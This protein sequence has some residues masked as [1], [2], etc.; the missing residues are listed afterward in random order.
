MRY[1]HA[2]VVLAAACLAA[3]VAA[4]ASTNQPG[5]APGPSTL[6]LGLQGLGFQTAPGSGSLFGSTPVWGQGDQKPQ[7]PDY[8][9]RGMFLDAHGDFMKRRE[10]FDPAVEIGASAWPN[11]RIRN[12]DGS[13]DWL[14]YNFDI[15]GH[16]VIAPDGYVTLGAYYK[17][18]SYN[19]SRIGQGPGPNAGGVGD[20]ALTGTGVRVGFGVFLD[21]N[22]LFEMESEP[23]IWSDMDGTLHSQDYDYPSKALFTYRALPELYLKIGARYN[24]IYKDAPWLPYLGVSWEFTPGVRIDLLAPES[25]ELS[26]WPNPSLGVLFGTEV[27]GAE[28]HVRPSLAVSGS[29]PDVRSDLRVQEWFAYVGLMTRMTDNFSFLARGGLVL[30]G[31]YDLTTGATGFDHAEGQLEQGAFVEVSFGF[32]W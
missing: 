15:D 18:R 16:I 2:R 1:H 26:W 24:Q 5:P 29:N 3:T 4:Q 23:G 21:D 27:Q 30:G 8:S 25:L 6:G 11:Q 9:L 20:E 32:D 10:R 22:W 12:E 31:Q 13:F 17:G 19:F 7:G 28:Y 14:G